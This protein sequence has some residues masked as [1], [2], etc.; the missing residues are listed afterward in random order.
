MIQ[1][2]TTGT[3]PGHYMSRALSTL[4]AGALRSSGGARCVDPELA[5]FAEITHPLDP[6]G[7]R[8][9]GLVAGPMAVL[10]LDPDVEPRAPW[11]VLE[12]FGATIMEFTAST[13]STAPDPRVQALGSHDLESVTALTLRSGMGDFPARGLEFGPHVGVRVDGR[14]VAMAGQ[15][16]VIGDRVEISWVSTDPQYRRLGLG[17]AVVTAAVHEVL[18][19]G[20]TPF[21]IVLDGNP[22]AA[23]YEHLGFTAVE[24]IHGTAVVRRQVDAP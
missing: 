24:R 5:A 2:S 15:R 4:P 11:S 17:A 19:G 22:A 1:S 18:A 9:L 10:Q 7:W 3:P 12:R 8:D 23:L 20:R 16:F 21:L 14:L 6:A 13:L